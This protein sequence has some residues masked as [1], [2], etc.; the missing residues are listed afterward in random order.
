LLAYSILIFSFSL[1]SPWFCRFSSLL[2]ALRFFL[3]LDDLL[4]FSLAFG[5]LAMLHGVLDSKYKL[6]A[7]C[8]QWTHQGG[9]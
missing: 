9:D 2:S 1:F 6:C 7:L 8:C 3:L 5:S 4:E